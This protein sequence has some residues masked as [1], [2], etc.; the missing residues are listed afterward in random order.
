[1]KKV[2]GTVA[3]TM[4]AVFAGALSSCGKSHDYEFWT[5]FGGAY[6][7]VL[8]GI[9]ADANKQ[10]GVDIGLT[11][12]GSYDGVLKTMKSAI[13]T[14]KYPDIVTGY[15]DH[16]VEYIGAGILVPLDKYITKYDQEFGTKLLEDYNEAYMRENLD[17]TQDA[18]GNAVVSG[19]PFNKSTEL[20]G[21]NGTFVDYCASLDAYK[22]DNLDVVPST[23]QEWTVKGPK[24]REILNS[25]CG[26]GAGDGKCLYGNQAVDGT[27][28][29]F[30]VYNSRTG[31]KKD[32][33]LTDAEGRKLLLDFTDVDVAK[34][35]IISWDSTDNMFITLIRQWGAEYTRLTD[36]E[37]AKNPNVRKGDI[38]F[39]SEENDNR[40]KVIECL[41][42]FKAL[43]NQKIFGVPKEFQ[44]SY[45]SA[46]FEQNQVM[47]MLCSSG[48]LSYNTAKWENRFRVHA[49][50]YYDDGKD[51]RKFVISQGA[52]IT[53]TKKVYFDKGKSAEQK[54]KAIYDC[55]KE[56]ALITT[57]D[58]QAE[59]CLQTGY[60]PCSKSATDTAKYQKFLKEA[61]PEGLEAYMAETGCTKAEAEAHA[62]ESATRVAYREGSNIN[63][64][65]YM[66]AD[67]NWTKFVDPAFIGSAKVRELSKAI[68]E[69]VF[70]ELA[71]D[72]PDSAY[73]QKLLD[74]VIE[75]ADIKARTQNINVVY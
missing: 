62:Y 18:S 35:R 12:K 15:P 34:T 46:A 45:S 10:L 17:L 4:L 51:V 56:I 21:Y 42:F 44:Q 49:L 73:D 70:I 13:Q 19:L 58:L 22:A 74:C 69:Q 47:F 37:K 32:G 41:K 48:G 72:A 30:K 60:Y 38:M 26:T 33:V 36:T 1:M 53:L 23:W 75:H 52:D 29:N 65:I 25:L 67:K 43:N 39:Y 20:M 6:T 8:E 57:G 11:S 5:N 50:P 63:E 40:A 27:A 2:K 64:S 55:F 61:T 16:F 66:D 28:S 3:L 68:F 71:A 24:Y 54:E 59:W 31:T 14:G 7:T 9:V